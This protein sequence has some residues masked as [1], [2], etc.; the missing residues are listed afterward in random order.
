[1]RLLILLILCSMIAYTTGTAQ[2]ITPAQPEAV[3]L[4]KP[5]HIFDGEAAEL[6][7]G[8]VVL[9]RGERIEA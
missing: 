1:M 9:V 8:W 3:Y 2:T 6:R 5:A 4:L 7:D